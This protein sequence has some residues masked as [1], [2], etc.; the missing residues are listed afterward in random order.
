MRSAVRHLRRLWTDRSGA[1]ALEFGLLLPVFIPV[2]FG[3][4]QVGQA[5]WTQTALQHAVEMAA[6]CATINSANC[7]STSLTQTYAATQAYGL[8]FPAGTFVA[9][10]AACG[11]QVT[12]TYSF[13]VTV[14]AWFAPSINLSARSCYPI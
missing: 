4:V 3:I 6:R 9:T 12:A 7:G 11:N 5:F 2:M 14:A 13:P 1:S 8:T 10:T